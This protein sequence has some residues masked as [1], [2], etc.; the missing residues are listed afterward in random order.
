MGSARSN[1]ITN[2]PK[3]LI[4]MKLTA[5]NSSGI[6]KMVSEVLQRSTDRL[7]LDSGGSLP[8]FSRMIWHH[9]GFRSLFSLFRVPSGVGNY[10]VVCM[11]VF[12][13][14]YDFRT[15]RVGHLECVYLISR[16]SNFSSKFCDIDCLTSQC[17]VRFCSFPYFDL[18]LEIF[19]NFFIAMVSKT[20]IQIHLSSFVSSMEQHHLP[21]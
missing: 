6:F 13:F 18:N 21:K 16:I 7:H 19:L 20:A 10:R 3:T 9:T 11:Y 17:N 8:T 2:L 15:Y 14:F 12:W 5:K 1:F 4:T